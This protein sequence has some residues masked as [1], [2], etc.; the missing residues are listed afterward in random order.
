MSKVD[1]ERLK[2]MMNGY[3]HFN[4]SLA[5]FLENNYGLVV[6]SWNPH[7]KIARFDGYGGTVTVANTPSDRRSGLNAAL[8]LIH[9]LE[10]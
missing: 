5:R 6:V 4:A 8:Q 10:A 9:L 3:K 2:R 1:K 7:V